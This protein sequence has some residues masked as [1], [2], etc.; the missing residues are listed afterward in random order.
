MPA[1]PGVPLPG[2]RPPGPSQPSSPGNI[3]RLFPAI[4]PSPVVYSPSGAGHVAFGR[5]DSVSMGPGTGPD[6]SEPG[7][8]VLAAVASAIVIST[9][10][11]WLA[12]AARARRRTR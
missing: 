4:S 12:V 6:A 2:V 11:W 10:G 8:A 5:Y 9:T 3:G 7:T 1:L